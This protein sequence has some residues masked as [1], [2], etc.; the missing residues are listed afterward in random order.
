[1]NYFVPTSVRPLPTI[2]ENIIPSHPENL[3]ACII[4]NCMNVSTPEGETLNFSQVNLTAQANETFV[5]TNENILRFHL[6]ILFA[7]SLLHK[8]EKHKETMIA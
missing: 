3:Y 8:D 1:M 6:S 2:Y 5:T 4:S 7:M